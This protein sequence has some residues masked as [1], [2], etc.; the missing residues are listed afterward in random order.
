MRAPETVFRSYNSDGGERFLRP[1]HGF[2]W[3]GLIF[4]G[5][6]PN[7]AL[8]PFSHPDSADTK[9]QAGEADGSCSVPGWGCASC[10]ARFRASA[11][12]PAAVGD[13]VNGDGVGGLLEEDAVVAD[14]EAEE[15]G[16][17]TSYTN[18][19]RACD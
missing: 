19:S 17:P 14:T 2:T 4:L 1:Q 12:S 3:P 13:T 8:S 11:V 5:R 7:C 9:F 18:R 10:L 16:G 15:A 6:V